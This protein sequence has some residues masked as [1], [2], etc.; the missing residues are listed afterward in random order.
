[1]LWLLVN[2]VRLRGYVDA[3]QSFNNVYHYFRA[4]RVV[5]VVKVLKRKIVFFLI[6]L[7]LSAFVHLGPKLAAFNRAVRAMIAEAFAVTALFK[8]T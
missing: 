6:V 1:V 3:C 2:S 4:V 8:V 7:L 5:C